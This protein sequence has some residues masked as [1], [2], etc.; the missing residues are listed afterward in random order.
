MT[1]ESAKETLLELVGTDAQKI[2]QVQKGLIKKINQDPGNNYYGEIL[3]W[4]YTQKNDWEGALIQIEAIDE[5]NQENG[6]RVM[7]FAR[8]AVAAKQYEIA[9]KGFDAIIAKGKDVP[10]YILA[11]SEKLAASLAQMQENNARKPEDIAALAALYDSFLVDYP[12]HYTMRTAADFATLHAVYGNN[13]KKAIDILKLA[14][15]EPDTR[16]NMMGVFKLQLGDYYLL[17]GKVWDASLTYSQVEKEFKQDVMGEDA[18]FRNARL[19]FYRGDFDLAQKQLGILK[20]GTTNLISN[21][22]IDLSVLIT[23][24]VE[25]SVTLPLERFATA[26]LLLFQN[27]DSEA[28]ALV[29]SISN[30]YPKHPLNDDLVMMRASIAMKHQ[31]FPKALAHLKEVIEK[32]GKD[33]QGDDAVYKTAEIYYNDLH[34]PVEA[35]KY[36]EQ[37]IIDYPGSTY[38]QAARQKLAEL[39]AQGVQ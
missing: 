15:A 33:V 26:G 23:E 1:A 28:E 29:D 9:N 34:Q 16:R 27:K 13:V 5:R 12:K 25:D 39:K 7:D 37:L 36:Y 35:K 3:T 11:R 31:D 22:A 4:I 30:A 38:A 17:Q 10:Y 8:T 32:Y 6:R 2:Q 20:S 24:N 21:D 18:R 14:I 19:A